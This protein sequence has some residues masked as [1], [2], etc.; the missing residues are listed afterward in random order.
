MFNCSLRA[1][2]TVV[3]V[4]ILSK[5][6]T[7]LAY[8][9]HLQY[10]CDIQYHFNVNIK[11]NYSNW[12]IK[13]WNGLKFT[14]HKDLNNLNNG[15]IKISPIF[16]DSVPVNYKSNFDVRNF[17]DKLFR[18]EMWN[19]KLQQDTTYGILPITKYCLKLQSKY[20]IFSS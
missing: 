1:S 7:F 5:N 3:H 10:I 15:I 8:V 16:D 6:P 20:I 11:K 18:N 4:H 13:Y 9:S 2:V 14:V 19:Y 17:I 12:S